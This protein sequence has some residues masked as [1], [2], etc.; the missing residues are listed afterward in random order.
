M[1][2]LLLFSI[3]MI[4]V[5][6]VAQ[7]AASRWDTSRWDT[8]REMTG[9]EIRVCS[10]TGDECLVTIASRSVGSSLREL[11]RLQKP[12]VRVENRKTGEASILSGSSGY[13]DLEMEQLVLV[14]RSKDGR[15]TETLIDLKTLK[16]T[17]ITHR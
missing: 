3:T 16:R 10:A 1:K 5:E 14:N 13:L 15:L 2:L 17:E 9:A 12:E 6:A 11:H 7:T 8:S 4:Q